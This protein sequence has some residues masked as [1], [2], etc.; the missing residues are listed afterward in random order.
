MWPPGAESDWHGQGH[1]AWDWESQSHHPFRTQHLESMALLIQKQEWT[2]FKWGVGQVVHLWPL[3]GEGCSQGWQSPELGAQ[4]GAGSQMQK[5]HPM[6]KKQFLLESL[7]LGQWGRAACWVAQG[8]C[9][10]ESGLR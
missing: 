7:P 1:E 8:L 5:R 3:Q 10:P 2:C 6:I 9:F 4:S